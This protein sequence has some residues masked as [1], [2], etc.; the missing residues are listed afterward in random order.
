MTAR[1]IIPRRKVLHSAL[2]VPPLVIMGT[3]RARA[4]DLPDPRM[5]V[6]APIQMPPLKFTTEIGTPISL[7]DFKGKF[8]L[9]NIWATWCGPCREEMPTLDR[10]Q[11]KLGGA[12]FQVAPLSIDAGGV[13]PVQ[14]FYRDIGIKHLS[15][16]LNISGDAMDSLNLGGVPASFLLNPDGMKIGSLVGVA[17]WSSP[18][19][20]AIFQKTMTAI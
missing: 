11:A 9:L 5:V 19:A 17:D 14:Q 1:K 4:E 13:T 16:Y 6:T 7:G 8:I 10:L 18:S 15:I 12:H 20:L 2:F 3:M